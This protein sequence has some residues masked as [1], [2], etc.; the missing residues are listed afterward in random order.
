MKKMYKYTEIKTDFLLKF[1]GQSL[2]V[3]V[4]KK[5]PYFRIFAENVAFVQK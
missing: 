3:S 2:L 4:K 5:R 1:F